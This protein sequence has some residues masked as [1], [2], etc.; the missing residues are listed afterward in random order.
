MKTNTL[1]LLLILILGFSAKAQ[2]RKLSKEEVKLATEEYI[3]EY[4]KRV[5]VYCTKIQKSHNKKEAKQY[6]SKIARLSDSLNTVLVGD[7]GSVNAKKSRGY[8]YKLLGGLVSIS[9]TN[10]E[11]PGVT[12]HL[13]QI[14]EIA[15]S[16][17]YLSNKKSTYKKVRKIK[18]ALNSLDRLNSKAL[19][20]KL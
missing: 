19:V 9:N 13:N 14:G 18:S 4:K 7:Y 3:D 5:T 10:I 16:I 1:T 2:I 20:S 6:A 8:T 15:E 11:V 17:S 12:P